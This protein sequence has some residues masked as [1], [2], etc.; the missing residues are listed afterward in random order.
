MIVTEGSWLRPVFHRLRQERDWGKAQVYFP[1]SRK[2]RSMHFSVYFDPSP[3]IRNRQ[4]CDRSVV[5]RHN[6]T[7]NTVKLTNQFIIKNHNQQL[8]NRVKLQKLADDYPVETRICRKR[9][10][11]EQTFPMK[12]LNYSVNLTS[13]AA[14]VKCERT[15]FC[16]VNFA[17]LRHF[18]SRPDTMKSSFDAFHTILA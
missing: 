14:P 8:V 10:S 13:K 16:H 15:P 12:I 2:I 11:I 18:R 7:M 9:H 1:V 5:K 4:E 17:F 6:I 3:S